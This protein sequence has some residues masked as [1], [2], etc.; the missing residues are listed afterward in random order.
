MNP[1]GGA[2]DV[3]ATMDPAAETTPAPPG[4]ASAV[5]RL[6]VVI[7]AYNEEVRLARTLPVILAY[8]AARD[9]AWE[10]LIVDDGS[11]DGTARVAAELGAGHPVRIIRN[12]PNRGKGY[13]IRRGM[14]EA[15]GAHRLFSDADLSTPIE[16]LDG[17]WKHIAA[18]AAVVIGSRDMPGSNLERPQ[19]LARE[20]AGRAFNLAVRALVLP[21]VTDTQCG[22]KLFKADAAE[23]VFS[24]QRLDGYAFDVEALALA[25]RHGFA[26]VEAP[27]RWIDAPGSK[28]SMARGARA[29]FDLLPL[30]LRRISG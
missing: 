26:V 19:P 3:P 2:S 11:R 14:L 13:S 9:Y 18:G 28:V 10:V 12:E 21:G 29:F 20:L 16:E 23:A 6:S 4:D 27:V 7:P 22:F 5:P 8:L 25:Q 24:R 15:R 1:F 17:F 30:A